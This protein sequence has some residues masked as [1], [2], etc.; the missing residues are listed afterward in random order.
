MRLG[1]LAERFHVSL[2]EDET[3]H[4]PGSVGAHDFDGHRPAHLVGWRRQ[5]V[6]EQFQLQAALHRLNTPYFVFKSTGMTTM[7]MPMV[8]TRR[9]ADAR[10]R[11]ARDVDKQADN[12]DQNDLVEI[13]AG[14]G[15]QAT[16]G[17]I[18]DEQ[19]DHGQHDRA[20]ESRQISQLA[21]TEGEARVRCVA[22]RL[23]QRRDQQRPGMR[24]HVQP[25]CH[26]GYRAE[27][28]A[29]DDFKVH[30]SWSGEFAQSGT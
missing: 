26:Q 30:L 6:F 17:L 9:V 29:T 25:A 5:T 14:G 7:A 21:F 20:G 16:Y 28:R 15:H 1:N 12:S 22:P 10:Q 23:R 24:R 18:A 27:H 4:L 13:D 3:K 11:N 8:V 19:R 2:P